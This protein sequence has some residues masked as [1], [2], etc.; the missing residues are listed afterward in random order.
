MKRALMAADQ[1]WVSLE[2]SWAGPAEMSRDS[3]VGP[4]RNRAKM[5]NNRVIFSR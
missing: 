3:G 4:E 1:V 5:K 2:G